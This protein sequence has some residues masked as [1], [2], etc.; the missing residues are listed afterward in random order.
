MKARNSRL[1]SDKSATG[2]DKKK[3]SIIV[4]STNENAATMVALNTPESPDPIMLPRKESLRAMKGMSSI[5][6]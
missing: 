6:S 2:L 3:S 5:A 1:V 4:L